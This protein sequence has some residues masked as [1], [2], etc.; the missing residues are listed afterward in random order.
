MR[1]GIF[2][3]KTKINLFAKDA[4][5]YHSKNQLKETF[6]LGPHKELNSSLE[7]VTDIVVY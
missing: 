3:Q 1:E 6:P 2:I 4:N 5:L 7:M